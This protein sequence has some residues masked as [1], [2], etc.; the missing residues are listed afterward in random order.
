MIVT[1]FGPPARPG[2]PGLF[3]IMAPLWWDNTYSHDH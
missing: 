3:V 1:A 2:S